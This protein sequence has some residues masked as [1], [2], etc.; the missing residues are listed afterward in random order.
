MDLCSRSLATCLTGCTAPL[1]VAPASLP[2][3]MAAAVH[4]TQVERLPRLLCRKSVPV[5]WSWEAAGASARD[6]SRGRGARKVGTPRVGE[7]PWTLPRPDGDARLDKLNSRRDIIG[8][9]TSFSTASDAWCRCAC[10]LACLP[11]MIEL[12]LASPSWQIAVFLPAS[13]QLP[14]KSYAVSANFWPTEDSWSGLAI[15]IVAVSEAGLCTSTDKV[16][17]SNFWSASGPD[18]GR[19]HQPKSMASDTQDA[20]MPQANALPQV[21]SRAFIEVLAR[22]S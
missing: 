2:R 21:F 9:R 19:G 4:L 7:G 16:F 6:G 20:E 13:A 17:W 22:C 3:L 10:N 8:E 1:M 11:D 15:A 18:P 14:E 12:A 5:C